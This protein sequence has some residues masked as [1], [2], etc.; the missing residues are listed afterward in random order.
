MKKK[1]T[2][3]K[4]YLRYQHYK[5]ATS[6]EE[7]MA[8]SISGRPKGQSVKKARSTAQADFRNDYDR[9]YIIFPGNESCLPGHI[10][11]SRQLAKDRV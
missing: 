2:I 11:N 8:L 7:F 10:F 3:S 1:K 9:G 5:S 4:S 6:Y